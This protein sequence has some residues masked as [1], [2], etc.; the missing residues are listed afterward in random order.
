MCRKNVREEATV[1]E[2]CR[3]FVSR[4]MYRTGET[5]TVPYILRFYERSERK[6]SFDIET[7]DFVARFLFKRIL[8]VRVYDICARVSISKEYSTFVRRRRSLK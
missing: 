1:Y 4:E 8:F 2:K 5:P 7:T 3:S 6:Y